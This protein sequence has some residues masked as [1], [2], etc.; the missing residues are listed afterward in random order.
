MMHHKPK[1]PR[2]RRKKER[3]EKIERRSALL[4][5]PKTRQPGTLG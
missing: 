1:K 2:K 4:H 3:K 5:P